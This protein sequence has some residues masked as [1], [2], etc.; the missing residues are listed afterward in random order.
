M[1]DAHAGRSELLDGTAVLVDR[2]AEVR[3]FTDLNLVHLE[4]RARVDGHDR[5]VDFLGD[6]EGTARVRQVG[7]DDL[8]A[9]ERQAGAGRVGAELRLRHV[10]R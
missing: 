6:E 7:Q 3:A 1:A 10:R 2:A 4:E 8:G 5:T 9:V